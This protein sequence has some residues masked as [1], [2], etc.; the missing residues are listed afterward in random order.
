[1]SIYTKMPIYPK[2]TA[3]QATIYFSN[4][5]KNRVG[6]VIIKYILQIIQSKEI[7]YV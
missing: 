2:N 6:G 5:L 4:L 3:R 7:N 1:M